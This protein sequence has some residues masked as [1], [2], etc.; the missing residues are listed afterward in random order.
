M[1]NNI[2]LNEM[3]DNINKGNKAGVFMLFVLIDTYLKGTLSEKDFLN[4][5]KVILG[6][7]K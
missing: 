4:D 7:V 6:E 5:I 1:F 2:I 3:I